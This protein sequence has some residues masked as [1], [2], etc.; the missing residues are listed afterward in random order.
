[1]YLCL[2]IESEERG[3]M[4]NIKLKISIQLFCNFKVEIEML[5]KKNRFF[6]IQIEVV[7]LIDF[8]KFCNIF[9]ER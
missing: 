6:Y 8:S 7:V 4:R 1:M 2:R 3:E 9:L 5:G